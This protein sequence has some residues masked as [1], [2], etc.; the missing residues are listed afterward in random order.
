M[1]L[2]AF[3]IT[4]KCNYNCLHCFNAKDNEKLNSEWNYEETI[5]FLDECKDCGVNSIFLTGGEPMAHPKFYEIIEEIYKRDMSVFEIATNGWYINQEGL[6]RLKKIGCKMSFKISF[7]GIGFHDWMR[8]FKGAEKRTIEA[9]KLCIKNGFKVIVHTQINK[10]NVESLIPTLELLDSLGVDETR[11][12]PTFH[13][14]KWDKNGKE[15]SFDGKEYVEASLKIAKEY[16]KKEHKMKVGFWQ[17][18]TIVPYNKIYTLTPLIGCVDGYRDSLPRC[19][20]TR[21]R[22]GVA[23]D[24]EVYPCLEM[25]GFM[26]ARNVSFGNVKKEGLRKILQS[27]KYLDYVGITIKDAAT[28]NGECDK[29]KYFKYCRGGCPVVGIGLG[30]DFYSPDRFKCDFFKYK[31]HKIFEKELMPYINRTHI[32]DEDE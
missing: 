32:D 20:G 26:K 18:M 2:I 23:S 7:D 28:K 17:L 15:Y 19:K 30:G 25:E 11:P 31:F 13:S 12:L 9:I 22:M 6:D 3:M 27:S 5:K 29:C 16:I 10:K 8:N 21:G 14:P 4:G 24:G 1:P